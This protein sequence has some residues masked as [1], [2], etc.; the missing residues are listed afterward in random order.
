MLRRKSTP[1]SGR[2][3]KG[4]AKKPA[5]AAQGSAHTFGRAAGEKAITAVLLAA[6]I[7][8]PI[9]LT[10]AMTAKTPAVAQQVV[11]NTLSTDQQSAGEYATSFVASWLS[12][13]RDRPGD[14][15]QYIDVSAVG[16]LS[17]APWKYRDL[18]VVS[19][20]P[21]EGEPDMVSVVVAANVE[22]YDAESDEG[23]M[24]WPRRYFSVTVRVA[25]GGFTI[26][27]LP[28]PVA[29][30]AKVTD[31]VKLVYTKAVPGTSAVREATQSF[32][33][34]Y[35]TGSGE[36]GRYLSPGSDIAAIAPAPYANLTIKELRSDAEAPEAPGTGDVVHVLALV[37]LVNVNGQQLSAT[38]TLTVTAR[39]GRWE[40]TSIDSTPILA[41]PSPKT[42]PKPSSPA[43]VT[44]PPSQTPAPTSTP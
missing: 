11:D 9:A 38:Y 44:D 30:P 15:K 10:V 31:P 21:A 35:L 16:Q 12:A 32:L 2:E 24:I 29:A 6:V 37:E 41:P 13:S 7:S 20:E 26:I 5:P 36:I 39:D 23:A 28:A 19:V 1:E 17:S 27:G 40:A 4:K 18:A 42:S 8:G 34:A 33:L 3:K 43:P 22:E 14:L 25:D